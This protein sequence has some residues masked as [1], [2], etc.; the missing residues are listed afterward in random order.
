V[1]ALKQPNGPPIVTAFVIWFV[2]FMVLW[3]AGEIWP[4]QWAA[5][6]VAWVVTPLAL[7][8]LGA[9]ALRLTARHADGGLSGWNHRFARGAVAIAMAAVVFTA[10]PSLIFVH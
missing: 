10:L 9:H 5:N 2:Q 3:A 1:K 6:A 4:H 8:A 7:L